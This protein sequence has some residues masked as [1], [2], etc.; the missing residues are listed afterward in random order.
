MTQVVKIEDARRSKEGPSELERALE[1]LQTH[2]RSRTVPDE[3]LEFVSEFL[4]GAA[5]GEAVARE[6]FVKALTMQGLTIFDI[7]PILTAYDQL[8]A[9]SEI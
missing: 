3:V 7:S 2:R 8:K 1:I 4:R 5:H 6:R 9:G